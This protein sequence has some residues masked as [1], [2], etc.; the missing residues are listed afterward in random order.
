[1]D[2]EGMKLILT[3]Q[4]LYEVEISIH[5]LTKEETEAW[6]DAAS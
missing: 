6:G 4:Q 5:L 1:M 2:E 3:N